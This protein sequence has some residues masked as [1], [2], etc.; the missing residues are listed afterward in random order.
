MAS[1]QSRFAAS[2]ASGEMPWNYEHANPEL[3]AALKSKALRGYTAL[4]M[5]CGTGND[6]I[7]LARNGFRVTAI[8]MVPRAIQM[9]R[10]RALEAGQLGRID[11]RIGDLLTVDLGGPFDV[12][13]DRGV[14]HY[15][16]RIDLP[17]FLAM[18]KRVTR[19]GTRWLSLSGNSKEQMEF[20]PPRVSEEQIRSELG[21]L[22][23]IVELRET[24]FLTD[25]PDFKPLAWATLLER[26]M[27]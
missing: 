2:Y 22:F 21:G 27:H 26:R 19:P 5:G 17:G 11:H 23:E 4:D 12:I 1:P 25:I 20:G 9:A 8:D 6:A 24:L 13:H 15:L 7:E 16:R 3:V 18:L 14:Y 10:A